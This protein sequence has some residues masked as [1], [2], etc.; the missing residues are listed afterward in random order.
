MRKPPAAAAPVT[1]RGPLLAARTPRTRGTLG[2]GSLTASPPAFPQRSPSCLVPAK[3]LCPGA[4]PQEQPGLVPP[5]REPQQRTPSDIYALAVHLRTSLALPSPP[6]PQ[7][8]PDSIRL[9]GTTALAAFC[10]PKGWQFTAPAVS[11]RVY[12]PG[13]HHPCRALCY[14]K[15]WQFT[16]PRLRLPPRARPAS[17]SA[18]CKSSY[19]QQRYSSAQDSSLL[20][21]F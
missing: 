4:G 10:Y 14:A 5:R 19:P 12:S 8:P 17:Q 6:L 18:A 20:S 7:G 3:P 15:D 11:P 1:P 13:W 16:A 9:D 21:F 2:A